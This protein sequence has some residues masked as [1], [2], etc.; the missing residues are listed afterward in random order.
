M[1]GG[2]SWQKKVNAWIWTSTIGMALAVKGYFSTAEIHVKPCPDSIAKTASQC[3]LLA[4]NPHPGSFNSVKL[5]LGAWLINLRPV[6]H[7]PFLE[8][9]PIHG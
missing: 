8:I 1:K 4:I 5:D 9:P 7:T 6:I 2:N 3:T